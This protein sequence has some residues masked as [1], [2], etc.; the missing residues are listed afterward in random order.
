ML[1]FLTL[2]MA[3]ELRIKKGGEKVKF[4]RRSYMPGRVLSDLH[5]FVVIGVF[6]LNFSIITII[7]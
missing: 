7:L 4:I 1:F 2:R 5:V 6:L 3:F